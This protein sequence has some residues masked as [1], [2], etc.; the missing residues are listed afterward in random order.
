[1]LRGHSQQGQLQQRDEEEECTSR[2]G[3]RELLL[4]FVRACFLEIWRQMTDGRQY[5]EERMGSE[6]RRWQ[7]SSSWEGALERKGCGIKGILFLE[8]D[9]KTFKCWY[10]EDGDAYF[11]D[12]RII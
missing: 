7:A 9:R 8:W 1:M 3:S 2:L 6:K 12:R 10:V 5:A 4:I 11:K